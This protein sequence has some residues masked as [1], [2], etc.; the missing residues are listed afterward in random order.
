LTGGYHYDYSII[1]NLIDEVLFSS[2]KC[3][4]H[5]PSQLAQTIEGGIKSVRQEVSKVTDVY[6]AQKAQIDRYYVNMLKDTQRE[7][8]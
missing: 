7:L 6:D 8:F 1:D 3:K 2:V 4:E 5:K